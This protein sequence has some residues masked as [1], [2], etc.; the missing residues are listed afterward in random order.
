M[1]SREIIS[2]KV[3]LAVDDSP[4]SENAF[5]YYLQTIHKKRN[6]IIIVHAYRPIVNTSNWDDRAEQVLGSFQASEQKANHIKRYYIQKVHDYE[7]LKGIT[8]KYET[9][10]MKVGE[11]ES[12]GATIVGTAHRAGCNLIVT[13][14]RGLDKDQ[15]IHFGSLSDYIAHHSWVPV[16]ICPVQFQQQINL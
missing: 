5:D 1:G 10:N 15:R 3:C 8:I 12:V 13:G 6:S 4:A 11:D 16:L 7:T 2:M 14:T 9:K